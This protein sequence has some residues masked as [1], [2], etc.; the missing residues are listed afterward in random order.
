MGSVPCPKGDGCI[1][2][3]IESTVTPAAAVQAGAPATPPAGTLD[4]EIEIVKIEKKWNIAN[5][6]I[7]EK[8]KDML[9]SYGEGHVVL[10]YHR[11]W[12]S[13]R[14]TKFLIMNADGT[15][16]P[17]GEWEDH[18]SKKNANKWKIMPLK[19]FL[20]KYAGKE[21]SA[22][23]YVSPSCNKSKQFSFR[24][25]FKVVANAN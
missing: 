4:F 12:G 13:C 16:L 1:E 10:F 9:L 15:Y 25:I 8:I 18:S 7:A 2:D 22:F 19:D 23:L 20:T 5:S 11:T 14:V 17:D 24:V 6:E 21:L 3:R